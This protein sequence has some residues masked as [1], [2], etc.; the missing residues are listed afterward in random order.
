MTRRE[1]Y[2]MVGLMVTALISVACLPSA[3][4][5]KHPRLPWCEM[6]NTIP[7]RGD[8]SKYWQFRA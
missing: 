4:N 2:M 6:P 3:K 7:P 5:Q 1:R 8:Q